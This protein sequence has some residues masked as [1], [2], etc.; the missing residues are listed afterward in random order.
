MSDKPNTAPGTEEVVLPDISQ[1]LETAAAAK[2]D[3]PEIPA[4]YQGKS[5]EEVIRMHQEAEKA[6][7]LA[8]DI[9]SKVAF[10]KNSR[11]V[12]RPFR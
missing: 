6:L 9:P 4:K 10:R 2:P 3:A 1:E 12:I 7:A 11:R 8:T 5:T